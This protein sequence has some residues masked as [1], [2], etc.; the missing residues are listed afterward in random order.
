MSGR[1]A[2]ILGLVA[3]L[4]VLAGPPEDLRA[5]IE[6]QIPGLLTTY[7]DLHAHPELSHHE[8]R[9]SAFLAGEL[10]KAGYSVTEHVGRYEDGSPAFGIAGILK[11]GPGPVVLLRTELDAL[12][13]TENTG[14]PFASTVRAK[15]AAGE[16]VGVMHACGHDLHMTSFLGTAR[17]LAAVKDMWSGTLVMIGQPSEET[18]DGAHA[19]LTDGL[20]DRVPKP[21]FAI[22]LHDEPT[23]EAGKVGI[24]AGPVYASATSVEVILRGIGGHGAHPEATK[25]PIVMAAQYVLAIQTIVSRQTLPLEPAVVTVGSIH[26]GSTKSRSASP[27]AHSTNRCEKTFWRRSAAWRAVSLWRPAFRTTARRQ[28]GS[29]NPRR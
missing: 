5:R 18:I 9:T 21:D 8:E 29:T 11:N 23:I 24:V 1:L 17:V 2:I 16:E 10:R 26:G 14:L 15:N 12:P 6:S 22:A 20:Y 25:D 13:V 3:C 7:R 19:M 4:P 27:C 28:S